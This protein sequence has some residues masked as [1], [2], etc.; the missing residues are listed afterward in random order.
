M[1]ISLYQMLEAA[2]A[3]AFNME[4]DSV[5]LRAALEKIS[6]KY[7]DPSPAG[8]IARAALA[9]ERGATRRILSE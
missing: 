9:N 6:N 3:K 4:R 5:R 7:P 1:G 2:S 8:M